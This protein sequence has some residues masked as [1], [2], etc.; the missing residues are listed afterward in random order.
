MSLRGTS[1]SEQNGK[2]L[3]RPGEALGFGWLNSYIGAIDDETMSSIA[4]YF[5]SEDYDVLLRYIHRIGIYK[6]R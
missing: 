2:G 4:E 6:Q 3:D 5:H 1:Q